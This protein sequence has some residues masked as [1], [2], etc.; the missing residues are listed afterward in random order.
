MLAAL[1]ILALAAVAAVHVAWRRRFHRLEMRHSLLARELE[2]QQ[3]DSQE[4]LADASSQL[5]AVFESMAEGVVVLGSDGRIQL[6][7]QAALRL[8]GAPGQLRGVSLLEAARQHELAELAS[9]AAREGKPVELDLKLAHPQATA[10]HV[11]ASAVR[12]ENSATAGVVLVLHDLTRLRQLEAIR[13]DFV[14]NVSHE[15][16][17]PLSVIKGYVETLLHLPE[18]PRDVRVR[19]LKTIEKHVE[20][21]VFLIE[22]LLT[23]SRLENGRLVLN[24][25]LTPLRALALTVMEDLQS[26]A[27]A[28]NVTLHN[29]I[30]EGLQAVCDPDRIRQALS[31]LVDN[32]IKYGRAGGCVWITAARNSSDHQVLIAVRDDGPGIPIEAQPR[33]FE[34]F[35]RVDPARSRDTGGT[36]LGLSIVK[37]IAQL[38]G[39]S[40]W[41]HSQPEHGS[42]FFIGL[43]VGGPDAGSAGE[44]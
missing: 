41:V 33:V 6:A 37:H 8:L 19:F 20:R 4:K 39:G 29:E 17:T 16:R 21:L 7:N 25:R 36:G 28:R 42:T 35:Y 15:L 24:K 34:R 14:A 3:K 43:P 30:P 32:A 38:H 2:A 31:N 10:L 13:T 11:T 5:A 26:S 1:L 12:K 18:Q 22:D 23:L 9:R 44:G 40:A 27:A